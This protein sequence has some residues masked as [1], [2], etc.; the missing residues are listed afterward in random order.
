MFDAHNY[1]V[2]RF[3]ALIK[4]LHLYTSQTKQVYQVRLKSN[5]HNC[6]MNL[7]TMGVIRRQQQNIDVIAKF[8]VLPAIRRINIHAKIP[9]RRGR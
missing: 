1:Y 6:I 4:S 8:L 9:T 5:V 7:Q 3:I 2:A